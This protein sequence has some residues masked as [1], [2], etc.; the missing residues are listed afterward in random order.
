MKT[1]NPKPNGNGPVMLTVEFTEP[2]AVSIAINAL[3]ADWC[4]MVNPL[5][6]MGDGRWM[7]SLAPPAGVCGFF[8]VAD[9]VPDSG[10]I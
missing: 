4:L 8:L 10:V 2:V 5:I 1:N 7:R 6:A 3:S 9:T